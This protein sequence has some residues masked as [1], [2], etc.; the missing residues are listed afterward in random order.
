MLEGI[1]AKYPAFPAAWKEL[2]TL[3]EDEDAR[4]QAITRGLEHGPDG[5]TKGM[6]LINRALILHRRSDRK[7]AVK[8]L[9]EFA[10]DPGSTWVRNARQD[11]AGGARKLS[12]AAEGQPSLAA[13]SG[14]RTASRNPTELTPK[15]RLCFLSSRHRSADEAGEAV[16]SAHTVPG[17]AQVRLRQQPVEESGAVFLFGFGADRVPRLRSS[18]SARPEHSCA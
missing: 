5:E 16:V 1:V 3:R 12:S 9:E 15:G 11:D 10:L 13:D 8:I 18:R 4:L 6:L 2:S 7:G 14:R 17:V